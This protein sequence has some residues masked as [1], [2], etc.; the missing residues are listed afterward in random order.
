MN[1]EKII[2]VCIIHNSDKSIDIILEKFNYQVTIP[3]FD[4]SKIVLVNRIDS[5]DEKIYFDSKS[6]EFEL[7]DLE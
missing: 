2:M 4:D 1:D 6:V 5:Q 7:G 3:E